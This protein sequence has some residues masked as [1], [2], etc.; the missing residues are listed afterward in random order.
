M[1]ELVEVLARLSDLERRVAGMARHGAV[2]EVNPVAA[3]VRLDFGGGFLSAAVPY[4]QIAGA[5][6]AHVPPSVG[7]Q[8]TLLA[9]SGDWR[10]AVAV[11]LTWSEANPS[12]E[13]AGDR[14]VVT[15]GSA[16][17]EL[18]AD[19]L[20]VTVGSSELRMTAGGQIELTGSEIRTDG[21]TVLNNGTR[22]VHYVGGVD[23]DGDA[24]VSGADGVLV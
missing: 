8:M 19:E 6:K 20:I 11:P 22:K 10:Q 13:T 2:A 24:A 23:S 12:P 15:F 9:P 18:R 21:T 7:Q 4:A 5:L 1:Q 16:R 3:T 17:I 14:H